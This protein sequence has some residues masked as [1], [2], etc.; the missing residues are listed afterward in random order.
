MSVYQIEGRWYDIGGMKERW[1]EWKAEGD[2]EVDEGR[3]GA[4]S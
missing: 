2:Y 1:K 4:V 3:R